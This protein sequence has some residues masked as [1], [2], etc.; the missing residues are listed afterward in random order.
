M[1]NTRYFLSNSREIPVFPAGMGNT[2]KSRDFANPVLRGAPGQFVPFLCGSI[3]GKQNKYVVRRAPLKPPCP[4]GLAPC[5]FQNKTLK[6]MVYLIFLV[7][8]HII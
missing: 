7:E 6:S 3:R 2:H 5:P 8:N 1:G 4:F